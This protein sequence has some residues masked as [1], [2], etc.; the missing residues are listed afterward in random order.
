MVANA[1]GVTYHKLHHFFF[2]AAPW[3]FS[4]LN[5]R[6]LEVMNQSHRTKISR[7]FSPIVDDSR[8][9]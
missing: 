4:A 8:Y 7:G 3:S 6:R 9:P 2:T 5:Q 1:V